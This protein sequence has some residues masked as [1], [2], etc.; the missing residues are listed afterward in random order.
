MWSFVVNPTFSCM[1][2][3]DNRNAILFS[4]KPFDEREPVD[5]IQVSLWY[6]FFFFFFAY[7]LAKLV[8]IMSG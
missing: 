8:L 1:V 6:Y 7:T 2:H 3:L 4:G 5:K